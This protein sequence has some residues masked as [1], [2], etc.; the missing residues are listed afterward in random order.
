VCLESAASVLLFFSTEFCAR[1]LPLIFRR[2]QTAAS[3]IKTL[4]ERKFMKLKMI[5]VSSIAVVALVIVGAACN[6]PSNESTP[7]GSTTNDAAAKDAKPYPFDT[8]LVD[9]MKL[10]SMG[11][12]YVFVYRGQEIKFC[13]AD[14]KPTFLKDPDTYMKKIQDA[15]AAAPK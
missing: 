8:C 7:A 2:A 1:D 6:H 15:E 5:I 3:E 14:C 11:N 9:G 10:G 4:T 13:C 12:P